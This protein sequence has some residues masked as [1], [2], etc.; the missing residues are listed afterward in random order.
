MKGTLYTPE[1]NQSNM[2]SREADLF[3]QKTLEFKF[4]A[5]SYPLRL[6]CINLDNIPHWFHKQ[7]KNHWTADY[8]R[9]KV[10]TEGLSHMG[11][12]T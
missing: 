7:A 12:S 3:I 9:E 2:P 8:V 5:F 4:D 6:A 11:V 10:G 1:E